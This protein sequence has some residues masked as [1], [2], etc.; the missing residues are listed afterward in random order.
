MTKES[1]SL[2]VWQCSVVGLGMAF[3]RGSS[4]LFYALRHCAA[5]PLCTCC[6][7]L[8]IIIVNSRSPNNHHSFLCNLHVPWS[9][10]TPAVTNNTYY[11]VYFAVAL[12]LKSLKSLKSQKSL[13]A[14][15]MPELDKLT[16]SIYSDIIDRMGQKTKKNRPHSPSKLG[17][18]DKPLSFGPQLF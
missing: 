3:L 14:L 2:A 12:C 10:K 17:D 5:P 11:L 13:N 7:P 1:G 15:K 8:I 18:L 6:F 9:R 4:N 16:Y